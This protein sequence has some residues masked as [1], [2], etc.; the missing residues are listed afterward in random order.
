MAF[1]PAAATNPTGVRKILPITQRV[2]PSR[3]KVELKRQFGRDR[4]MAPNAPATR[5]APAS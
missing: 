5:I 3:A 1:V 4:V 2:R